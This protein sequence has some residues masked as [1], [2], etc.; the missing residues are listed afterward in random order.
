MIDVMKMVKER[1]KQTKKENCSQSKCPYS[2]IMNGKEITNV[3][4]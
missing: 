3:I 1:L 4:N 2:I